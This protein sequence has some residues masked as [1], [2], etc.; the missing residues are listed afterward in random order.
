MGTWKVKIKRWQGVAA[1]TW[2]AGDDVCGIC[3]MP[4]DQGGGR[5]CTADLAVR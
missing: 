5:R 2:A 1:W 4:F 3:H